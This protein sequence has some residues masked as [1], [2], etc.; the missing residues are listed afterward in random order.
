MAIFFDGKVGRV[1]MGKKPRNNFCHIESINFNK[2]TAIKVVNTRGE[3]I[4]NQSE[5]INTVSRYSMKI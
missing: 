3:I 4:Y 5:I 1:S 2:K